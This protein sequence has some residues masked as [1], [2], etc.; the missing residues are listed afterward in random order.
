M[1]ICGLILTVSN[2]KQSGDIISV[3]TISS[4][5]VTGLATSGFYDV[6]KIRFKLTNK[7]TKSCDHDECTSSEDDVNYEDDDTYGY[8]EEGVDDDAE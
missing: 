8:Y 1:A 4:G 6:L 2:A 3:S 5:L 7:K